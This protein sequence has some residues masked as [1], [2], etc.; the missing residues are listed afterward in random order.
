M[1]DDGSEAEGE[2]APTIG[3]YTGTRDATGQRS[4]SDCSNIFPNGDVYKGG[5]VSGV[6]GETGTYTWKKPLAVYSGGYKDG[7]RDG[8]GKFVYPDASVYVGH[9]ANGKRHGE[10][11]YTYVNGDTY[12]GHWKDDVRHGKGVYTVAS[13][14]SKLEGTWSNGILNGQSKIIHQ[15]HVVKTNFAD[16]QPG[17]PASITF[18]STAYTMQLGERDKVFLGRGTAV[19]AGGDGE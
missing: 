11:R 2:A 19:A 10:G 6:R 12:S 9:F 15:D 4:G 8:E 16:G 1:S 5:Y 3:T 17:L 7:K 14:G 13:S 18:T